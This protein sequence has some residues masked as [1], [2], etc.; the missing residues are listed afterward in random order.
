MDELS[1]C[2]PERWIAKLHYIER[3][4]PFYA[5]EAIAPNTYQ[6]DSKDK[7]G[8]DSWK[9]WYEENSCMKNADASL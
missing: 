1:G 4:Y 3:N 5:C 7:D 6:K 9:K 8:G 2:S